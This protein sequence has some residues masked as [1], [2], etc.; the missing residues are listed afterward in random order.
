MDGLVWVVQFVQA[1][2]ET[3]GWLEANGAL[4]VSVLALLGS[5]ATGYWGWRQK[6][7]PTGEAQ[8][9]DERQ[10]R[11]ELRSENRDL[12]AEIMEVEKLNDNLTT[13][14]REL[15]KENTNLSEIK[16]KL[17]KQIGLLV[18]EKKQRDVEVAAL[19]EDVLRLH[20]LVTKLETQLEDRK[21][22]Q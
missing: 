18:E 11:L 17:E 22:G 10:Y 3:R 2:A 20:R 5:A 7:Q 14:N 9:D 12:K 13:Q 16:D 4:V 1:Q 21:T 6:K 19:K 8:L 15:R